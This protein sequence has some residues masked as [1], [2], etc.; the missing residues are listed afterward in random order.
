MHK[1]NKY[2]VLKYIT[3]N[4]TNNMSKVNYYGAVEKGKNFNI[5][6]HSLT[7]CIMI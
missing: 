4:Y 3:N 7:T 5:N 1:N 2:N 6:H